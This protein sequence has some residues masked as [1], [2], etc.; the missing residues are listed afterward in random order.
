LKKLAIILLLIGLLLEVAGF[1]VAY[2]ERFPFIPK[3]IASDYVNAC[4]AVQLLEN[5]KPLLPKSPGFSVV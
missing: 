4:K 5:K 3:M 2:P 1:L